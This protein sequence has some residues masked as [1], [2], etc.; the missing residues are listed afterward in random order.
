MGCSKENIFVEQASVNYFM[1]VCTVKSKMCMQK[2]LNVIDGPTQNSD[3]VPVEFE[4]QYSL[5]LNAANTLT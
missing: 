2:I 4:V 1:P 5:P 3:K